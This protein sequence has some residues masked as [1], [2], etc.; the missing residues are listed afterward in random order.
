MS[1]WS[2]EVLLNIPALAVLAWVLAKGFKLIETIPDRVA[3]ALE[4]LREDI[5]EQRKDTRDLTQVIRETRPALPAQ[6]AR[7]PVHVVDGGTAS[8]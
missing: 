2:P 4:P 5:K 7:P 6:P 1:E 8:P 3:G